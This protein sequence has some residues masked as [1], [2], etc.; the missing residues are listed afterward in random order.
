MRRCHLK[1]WRFQFFNSVGKNASF[2]D[3]W[4]AR[5]IKLKNYFSRKK[6]EARGSI[7]HIAQ[8]FPETMPPF[9]Q[10]DKM[11]KSLFFL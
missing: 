6:C 4:L 7:V 10:Y 1:E 8:F 11:K 5:T 2:V 3:D 9:V